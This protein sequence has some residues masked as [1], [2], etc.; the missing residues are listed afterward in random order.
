MDD[1]SRLLGSY[2]VSTAKQF[3]TSWRHYEPLQRL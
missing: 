1:G 3:P 2:T